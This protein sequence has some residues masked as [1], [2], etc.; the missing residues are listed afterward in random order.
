MKERDKLRLLLSKLYEEK[1]NAETSFIKS[2]YKSQADT[3][4]LFE[5]KSFIEYKFLDAYKQLEKSTT[6]L[7]DELRRI[8]YQTIKLIS[9][10]SSVCICKSFCC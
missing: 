5:K 10:L 1:N 3:K 2:K 9:D 8:H 4:E 6:I 7:S